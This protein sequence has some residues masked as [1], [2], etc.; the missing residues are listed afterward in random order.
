VRNSWILILLFLAVSCQPSAEEWHKRYA[1]LK[2]D[3]KIVVEERDRSEKQHLEVLERRQDSIQGLI[4]LKFRIQ[5]SKLQSFKKEIGEV[6][7]TYL[8]EYKKAQDEQ[9]AKH[10]HMGTPDY[11]RQLQRLENHRATKIQIIDQKV[12][13]EEADL[14]A[15]SDYNT[16]KKEMAEVETA[17]RNVKEEVKDVFKPKLDSLQEQV[18]NHRIYGRELKKSLDQKVAK[19]FQARIDSINSNPCKYVN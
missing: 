5:K 19:E 18:N 7:E 10:G 4:N 3:Y 6:E 12:K 16:L 17:V 9:S 11:D 8:V 1:K 13:K 2:C 15:N 14:L